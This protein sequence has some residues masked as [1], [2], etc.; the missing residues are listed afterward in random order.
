MWPLQSG[1]TQQK[2]VRRDLRV[3]GEGA[4]HTPM[5]SPACST[6]ACAAA[7]ALETAFM[8]IC[9]YAWYMCTACNDAERVE[10]AK[11][12]GRKIVTPL[13][14]CCAGSVKYACPCC[15]VLQELLLLLNFPVTPVSHASPLCL[16]ADNLSL[17]LLL[18]LHKRAAA[19]NILSSF[20]GSKLYEPFAAYQ[21]SSTALKRSR[22]RP[23][24]RHSPRDE[25]V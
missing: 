21:C 16:L 9:V 4:Q 1:S 17:L 13:A 14:C 8:T 19:T 5:V 24:R 6:A 10:L 20:T 15:W 7:A 12:Y 23:G 22:C 25:I 11:R 2:H 18:L 3:V